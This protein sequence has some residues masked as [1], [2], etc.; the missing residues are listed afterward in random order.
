LLKELVKEGKIS[1]ERIDLSVSRILRMKLEIGLFENPYP[2]NDRFSKIG[3]PEHK[4]MALEAARESIVLMKNDNALPLQPEKIKNLVVA[5][6]VANSKVALGGGWTLRWIPDDE[7]IYPK[8]MLTVFTALQKEFAKSTVTLASNAAEVKT[9]AS[10]ADAIIIAVGEMAYSEG[11]GSIHDL[12]LPQDQVELIKAAQATGKP[13][14]I[15][16]VAG[17]PRV[18]T[19]IFKDSKAVLFAGWPGFEGAQ[20]IAEIISGKVNPSGKLAF[21]YPVASNRLLPHYHKSSEVLLAH[22]IENPITLVPYG[23]GLS[24][25]NFEYSNLNLTDSTLTGTGSITA[26]VNVKNTGTRDG[27]ESVLWFLQ[28][29]VGSISRPVRELKYYEKQSLKPGESKSFTFTIKPSE[30]LSFPDKTGK[31][32]MEDGYFTLTVGK[33]KKRFKLQGVN[34][35]VN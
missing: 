2:R 27:K 5:G 1:M 34:V 11:F 26:T 14:I 12:A 9:K 33:L 6:P 35:A 8:T 30:H 10:N 19:N 23:S 4:A 24:Y 3:S 32:L 29:E 13:V 20:A 16:L 18:I 21:N 28:D 22:E 15:V 25:T 7:S 17:R 31:M